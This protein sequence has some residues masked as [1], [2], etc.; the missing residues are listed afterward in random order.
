M[1]FILTILAAVVIGSILNSI[2][3]IALK[4]LH[5]KVERKIMARAKPVTANPKYPDWSKSKL[6]KS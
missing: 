2:I 5:Y 3:N 1:I 6:H 4:P